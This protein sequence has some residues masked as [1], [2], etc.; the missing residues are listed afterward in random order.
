MLTENA[1]EILELVIELSLHVAFNFS[2]NCLARG[3]ADCK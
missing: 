1:K 3:K 2:R